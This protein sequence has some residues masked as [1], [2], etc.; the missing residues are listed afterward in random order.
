MAT[1]TGG[2]IHV[3]PNFGNSWNK[4]ADNRA[5]VD[6]AVSADGQN[7][8]AVVDNGYIWISN[9]NGDTWNTAPSGGSQAWTSITCSDDFTKL[10]A[11]AAPGYIWTSEDS[12]NT[13]MMHTQDQGIHE[14]GAI[15]SS[16]DGSRLVAAERSNGNIWTSFDDPDVDIYPGSWDGSWDEKTYLPA[17]GDFEVNLT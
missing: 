14:W 17:E 4:R 13:F 7:M 5:W 16:A 8:T 1:E 3:S 6:V 10:A 2:R 11:V 9:D 15:A 12:G